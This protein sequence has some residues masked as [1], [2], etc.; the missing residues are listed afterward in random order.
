MPMAACDEGC[1]AVDLEV[2]WVVKVPDIDVSSSLSQSERGAGL[3]PSKTWRF[4]LNMLNSC[5]GTLE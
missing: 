1:G 2:G 5:K 4:D 3:R